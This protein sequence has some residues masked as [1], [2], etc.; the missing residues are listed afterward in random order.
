MKKKNKYDCT[1][2]EPSGDQAHSECW[3]NCVHESAHLFVCVLLCALLCVDEGII[4]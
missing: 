1:L 2:A 4:H 3:L